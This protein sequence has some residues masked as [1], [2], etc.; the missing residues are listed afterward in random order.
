M[1]VKYVLP[2]YPVLGM[3]IFASIY[4][5]KRKLTFFEYYIYFLPAT[6]PIVQVLGH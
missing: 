6:T 3:G 4:N 1:T 5:K 2:S